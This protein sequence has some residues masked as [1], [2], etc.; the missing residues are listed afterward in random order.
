MRA[1]LVSSSRDLAD[2]AEIPSDGLFESLFACALQSHEIV[3][4]LALQLGDA[5][6]P[7]RTNCLQLSVENADGFGSAGVDRGIAF[8]ARCSEIALAPL[9]R[10][11][12]AAPGFFVCRDD[13]LEI[14]MHLASHPT[15]ERVSQSGDANTHPSL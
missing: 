6:V 14:G 9:L 5:F 10:E 2:D 8:G 1:S 4:L 15:V 12:D 3:G 7:V 13:P 11:R